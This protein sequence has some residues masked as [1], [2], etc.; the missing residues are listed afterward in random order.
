MAAFYLYV[1]AAN[2]EAILMFTKAYELDPE[3]AAAYGMAARS[4]AQ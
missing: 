3:Y 2:E 4:Y 1:K